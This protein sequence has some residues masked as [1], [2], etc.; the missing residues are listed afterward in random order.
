MFYY[1]NSNFLFILKPL[2]HVIICLLITVLMKHYTK[3]IR[4]KL[5]E[6]IKRR[7]NVR[8][9]EKNCSMPSGDSMQAANFSIIFYCYFGK[10]FGFFLII[11]VMISRIFF[12]C[13]YI[14]D[15]I[16]GVIIGFSVSLCL[17]NFLN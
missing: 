12:C 8:D 1:S 17:F 13:H 7:F 4:P 6:N 10:I 3:R 2:T 14:M 11:P 5:Y 15:T 16:V 9:R